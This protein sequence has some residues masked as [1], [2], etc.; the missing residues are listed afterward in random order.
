V[1]IEF[2]VDLAD[3]L[4]DSVF[5]FLQIRPIVVSGATGRLQ[6]T[7]PEKEA[8][9]LSSDQALGFG[10]H[11]QMRDILFVRP[12]AFDRAVTREIAAEIGKINR[13]RGKKLF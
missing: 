9:F 12:D 8:A 4:A 7:G 11:E 5:Y 6:I 10:L 13:T 2:A 3:D 1:E